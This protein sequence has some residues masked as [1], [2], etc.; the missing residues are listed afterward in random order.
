MSSQASVTNA[1][2]ERRRILVVDDQATN[3]HILHNLLGSRHDVFMTTN[4]REALALCKAEQPDLVLLDIQMPELNGFDVCRRLKA[5]HETAHIPVIFITASEASQDETLG[6][7]VGAVDF[8]SKPINPAVVVARVNTH[9]TIKALTDELRRMANVDALTGLPNRRRFDEQLDLEWRACKRAQVPLGVLMIDV[10]HFKGYND[11]YGHQGGDG[12]LRTVARVLGE[13]LRRP[14][15]FVARYGGEEFSCLLPESDLAATMRTAEY[16]RKQVEEAAIP[17][18]RSKVAQVVTV[19]LG[20][21]VETPRVE[22]E[23]QLVR[24]ADHALYVAKNCG[25]NRVRFE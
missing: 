4:S 22:S 20:V 18:A 5:C 24:Q 13:S 11:Y 16:L 3:V 25:R 1:T 10:D 15:D 8:I 17:H 9:L 2:L 6:L 12:A 21:A 14:R 19:S 7:E 23:L